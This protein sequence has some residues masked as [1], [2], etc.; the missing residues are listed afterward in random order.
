MDTYCFL[1]RP[2]EKHITFVKMLPES[3]YTVCQPLGHPNPPPDH[4]KL[5]SATTADYS[6]MSESGEYNLRSI[7]EIQL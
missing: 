1:R 3:I 7:P 2:G 6:N 5:S 4:C